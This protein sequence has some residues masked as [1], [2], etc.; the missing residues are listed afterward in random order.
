MATADAGFYD[1]LRTAGLRLQQRIS[2]DDVVTSCSV[3]MPGDRNPQQIP[4]WFF[5]TR[6]ERRTCRFRAY[7]SRPQR[8]AVR[9]GA[10]HRMAAAPGERPM[11]VWSG[12]RFPG[13]ARTVLADPSWP[14]LQARMVGVERAAGEDP[15]EV[16]VPVDR[17]R[18]L[19]SADSVAEVLT[20]RL[21]GWQRQRGAGVELSGK[22]PSP[23]AGGTTGGSAASP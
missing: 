1:R 12:R 4:I 18:E 7:G 14:V 23:M 2:P 16:P 13:H 22:S 20:W 3:A 10:G 6:L 21:Y 8:T 9:P 15:V 17:Q 11:G 19:S 5:G